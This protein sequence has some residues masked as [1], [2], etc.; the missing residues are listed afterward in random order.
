MYKD[1]KDVSHFHFL[2]QIIYVYIETFSP[3][4]NFTLFD[5]QLQGQNNASSHHRDHFLLHA[6]LRLLLHRELP[7]QKC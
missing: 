3:H 5:L 6:I 1:N 4:T 7:V 2:T